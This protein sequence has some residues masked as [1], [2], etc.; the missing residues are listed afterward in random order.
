MACYATAVIL[1]LRI[2]P[3]SGSLGGLCRT[4]KDDV[5]EERTIMHLQYSQYIVRKE[6]EPLSFST[7]MLAVDTM[8]TEAR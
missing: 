8:C 6:S 3:G 2:L 7:A 5:Q 1:G 4:R